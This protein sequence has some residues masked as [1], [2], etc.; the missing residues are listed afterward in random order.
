MK[1]NNNKTK[2]EEKRENDSEPF[3]QQN[4]WPNKFIQFSY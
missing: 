4:M 2:Q 1:S 3:R